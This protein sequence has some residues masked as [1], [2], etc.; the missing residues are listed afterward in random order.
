MTHRWPKQVKIVEVAPRDGLQSEKTPL[1]V[2][3]RVA[4]INALSEAGMPAIEVG[5]FVSAEKVPSMA[6]SDEVFQKI[7]QKAG[8]EYPV[9]V[10]NRQG[11][12]R[13]RDLGVKYISIFTAASETFCLHNI[14]CSIEESYNRFAAFLPDARAEGMRIRGYVS[15][16]AGCPYEGEISPERVSMVVGNL[17]NMGCD[18]I[19]LGDTIGVGT[20]GQIETLLDNLSAPVEK[21]AVHFHNTYGQALANILIALEKGVTII[22]SSSSGLGGCPYAPGASGNVATEDVV[23]ML[24]GMGIKTGVDLSRVLE[25]SR[26]V[27][28]AL[29]RENQSAYGRASIKP[30]L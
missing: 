20:P 23:Y 15:C 18:E 10:P 27:N 30:Y 2:K 5:S 24:Q 17:L 25:A 3:Q 22:D 1:S 14:N 9:L 28:K 6:L 26:P 12:E 16:V 29:G 4:F 8:V 19:S 21:L 11:F 7:N 13:A